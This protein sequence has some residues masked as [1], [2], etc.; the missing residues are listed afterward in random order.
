MFFFFF[1]LFFFFQGGYQQEASSGD[2]P[3]PSYP[4]YFLDYLYELGQPEAQYI[5]HYDPY[6]GK[7]CYPGSR[8]KHCPKPCQSKYKKPCHCP[9]QNKKQCHSNPCDRC[10]ART[11][12][13]RKPGQS[14][15]IQFCHKRDYKP[16]CQP[17]RTAPKCCACK[18]S[19]PR[20]GRP[21]KPPPCNP[22][23]SS[24]CPQPCPEYEP[25]LPILPA[26]TKR[27]PFG[28]EMKKEHFFLDVS[29]HS[30]TSW[31]L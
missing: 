16:C 20:P 4:P 24:P 3:H 17:K 31:P 9:S 11:C 19:G 7:S 15:T 8:P 29:P 2:L 28:Y 21:C 14:R 22:R 13:D 1:L 5:N 27:V 6:D 18:C 26:F 12:H 10:P 25:C 30:S 23:P